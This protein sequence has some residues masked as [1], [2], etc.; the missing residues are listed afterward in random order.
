MSDSTENLVTDGG[1]S[2]IENEIGVKVRN[3]LL[4]R[5]IKED[6][7]TFKEYKLRRKFVKEYEKERNKG[8]WLWTSAKEPSEELKLKIAL[9]VPG[10]LESEEFSEHRGNNLGTYNKKEVKEFLDSQNNG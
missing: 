2:Y 1:Y 7:E 6:G 5:R 9:A 3:S 4:S 8:Q 10:V